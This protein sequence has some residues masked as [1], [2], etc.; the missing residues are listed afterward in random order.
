VF[1]V[2]TGRKYVENTKVKELGKKFKKRDKKDQKKKK[3][4][5]G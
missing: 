2:I 3:K 1:I 5:E 4:R